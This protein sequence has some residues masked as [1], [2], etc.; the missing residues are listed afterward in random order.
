[1][2]NLKPSKLSLMY[3]S[4]ASAVDM[5][6][7]IARSKRQ[8]A[9]YVFVTDDVMKN[10]YDRLPTFYRMEVAALAA[11]APAGINCTAF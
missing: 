8:N 7:A 9:G 1:M 6:K 2:C 11:T 3:H 10:P 5:L 4:A